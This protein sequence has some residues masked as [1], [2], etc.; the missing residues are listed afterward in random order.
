MIL[1]HRIRLEPTYEQIAYFSR[2]C[3]VARFAY[4]WALAEWRRQY[5]SGGKPSE[6]ALRKQLNAIKGEQFPWMRQVTKNAP[7]QAIKNLGRAHVN[8]FED[9]AKYRRGEIP[10]KRVRA[11]RFKM[12]GRHDAFRADNGPDKRHP[13]AVKTAGKRV[14]L[15]VIGWVAMREECAL[16][17]A[18]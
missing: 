16:P 12:K 4:N 13:H 8:F 2:A 1:G 9:L 6:L 17:G 5:H 7:Q 14:R 3:G 15:P 11:P 10:W 18:S